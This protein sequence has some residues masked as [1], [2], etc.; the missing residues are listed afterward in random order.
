VLDL[1]QGRFEGKLL[2][3]GEFVIC[4]DEKPLIQARRRILQPARDLL[5][6]RPAQTARAQR[7]RRPRRGRPHPQ[8]FRAALERDRRALRL[9]LHP[10]RPR[11]ADRPSHSTRA[12][13]PAGRM[14]ASELTAGSTK[15]RKMQELRREIEIDA[16]PERVWAVV[17]D[18]AAYPEWNPFIRRIRGELHEGEARGA[19]RAAG[20]AGDDVQARR[21]VRGSESRAA[22]ARP[23]PLARR[24]RRRAQPPARAARRRPQPLRSVRAVHRRPTVEL[25]ARASRC[26]VRRCGMEVLIVPTGPRRD[27]S[28]ALLA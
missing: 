14:I 13:A 27:R 1:Y 24:L 6:D 5:L 28:A 22:L 3:P 4:A 25:S 8:R 21:S 12:S 9:A 17:T 2:H 10:R 19:N 15:T 26:T 16:P 7:L 23:P 18:F 11:R 20:G